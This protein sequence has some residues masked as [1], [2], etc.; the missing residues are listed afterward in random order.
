MGQLNMCVET[1][2]FFVG[3]IYMTRA[4]ILAAPVG[5]WWFSEGQ[6]SLTHFRRKY[7]GIFLRQYSLYTYHTLDSSYY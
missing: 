4:A 2:H 6:S 1:I 3:F 7:R 5:S